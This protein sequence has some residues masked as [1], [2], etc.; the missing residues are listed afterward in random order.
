M[1]GG[2][3]VAPEIPT[4]PTGWRASFR[5]LMDIDLLTS[6]W[7]VFLHTDSGRG[8]NIHGNDG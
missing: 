8:E 2:D 4:G 1:S 7:S 5:G 6:F 3:S